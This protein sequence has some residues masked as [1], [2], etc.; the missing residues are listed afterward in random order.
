VQTTLLGLAIAI[1]LALVAALVGPLFVDWG[2]YRGE[3][4]ARASRLTGLDFRVTG[5]IDARVLPTPTIVLQGVE[6][7][8]PREIARVRARALRIEFALGA[9]LRGEWRIAD[10]RLEGPELTA[11]LDGSG[12]VSWPVP[13]HGFDLDGVSIERLQIQDGRAVLADGA[14]DARVVLDKLDFKGELRSLAGPVKGA[15][16]FVVGE[17]RYPYRLST[18]HIANDGGMK[19]RLAVDP[20]DHSLT[21]EA[22]ITI[23][24][25]AAKPRF[26]GSIQF[27]RPVGR[28]PTGADALIVDSWRVSSR[29]KGDSTAAVFEQIEFQ[30]GPDDRAIKLKGS[31]NVTFGRQPQLN[32]ALT[33]SQIDVDRVLALPD[34]ARRRPL[35]GVRALAEF[36]LAAARL[37][38][39]VTLRIGVENITLGGATLARVAADVRTDADGID[40]NG[41][42]LRAPG[43]TQVRLNGRLAAGATGPRFE[44]STSIEATDPRTFLAWLTERSDDQSV[45]AGPLRLGADVTFGTDAV[46]V[47]RLKLELDRMT[48]A[49]RLAYAWANDARPARLDVSL[50]APEIDLDRVHALAKAMLGDTAFDWPRAGA[51]ALKV[52]RAMIAGVEAKRA[53]VN[54]RIGANGIE[55]DRLVIADF[56]GTALAVKGRIDSRTQ[57]PR[58]ALTLDLDART[59]DGLTTLVE[60]F[61][62]QTADQ[63]R[64]S[65]GRLTPVALR[66][67]LAVD[68]GAAGNTAANAKFK[69]DGRAGS[70]RIALQGDTGG[71]DQ[72]KP[73]N[74]AALKTAKTGLSLRVDADDGSALAEL[75]GL[76]RFIA[77]DKRPGRLVV[78]ARG[79][80]DGELALDG[81]FAAGALDISSNGTIRLVDPASPTAGLNIKVS[82]A[83]VRSPRPVAAGRP[84]ELVPVSATAGLDLA[85]GRLHFTDLAGTV[86]GTNVRGRLTLGMRQQPIAVGGDIEVGAANLPPLIALAIGIPGQ[87]VG[88][89]AG[90]GAA[91]STASSGAGPWPAEPF[92]QGLIRLNG[93]VSV[94]AARVALTPKL[95]AQ[96]VRGVL[97]FGETQLALQVTDGTLAGGRVTGELVFLRDGEGLIARSR[98]WLTAANAAELLPG[99]GVL[100]GRLTL[101]VATEGTGMSAVALV[102]SLSGGGTFKL[103]NARVVRL[104]PTAFDTV[105]RAVDQGLP[106]DAARIRDRM[107]A[108][109]A[110]GVLAVP[111]AEGAITIEAGQAR[112]GSTTVSAQRADVAVSGGVNLAEGALDVLLTLS[113]A[114]G[115]GAPAN[116]RPE[117]LVALK[118]P[119]DAP[120]RTV[121][122]AALASWLA[123]RAVEQ[124]SKKLDV[125]EG[126]E[127]AVTPTRAVPPARPAINANTQPAPA[128]QPAAPEAAP[129]EPGASPPSVRT[130]PASVPKPK[131]AAPAAEQRAPPLPPPIDI[132]PAPQPSRPQPGVQGSP[133]HP[134]PQKP[135]AATTPARPRSLSEILFGR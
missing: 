51:L 8:R 16:S 1:I 38:M 70:F 118:G 76:D 79:P 26:D 96:D 60:K 134:Q 126:R 21:A 109:L 57:S 69:V 49:G 80:L 24:N 129:E 81:Q 19:V 112:L 58:G 114:S 32:G 28:A 85:D 71:D 20:D 37:P 33:S 107:D 92:E 64:R 104:D 95:S 29:I 131:P 13:K 77:V 6:F 61:A 106:I 130:Q 40:I 103:E 36:A 50:A 23:W 135:A 93:Q 65:A 41:L 84:G 117:V 73:D 62:P 124:Q 102:G 83:N 128:A 87:N 4:E 101:N 90:T 89:S 63:L 48:V 66:A 75:L 119:L 44:G 11:Q 120:K 52:E 15:G 88:A 99:E 91:A 125:L 133:S 113:G 132:R 127:P 47:D 25:D 123:L 68:P 45:I 3:F 39:P 46:A 34:A 42:E 54:L 100:S 9:L 10:A 7:G 116:T 43:L 98:V 111:L 30:Y 86:A 55:I 56:G 97:H 94:K 53:D 67:S 74:L 115:P 14:S 27:A 72:F 17:Q 59:L 35:G 18:S 122:V 31:A 12:R 110:R 78:A 2:S 82:N 5:A 121:D 22:D 108:A 105:I